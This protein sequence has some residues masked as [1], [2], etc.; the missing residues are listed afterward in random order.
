MHTHTGLLAIKFAYRILDELLWSILI[1]GLTFPLSLENIN[2][3]TGPQ[4]EGKNSHADS[5]GW[6]AYLV[7]YIVIVE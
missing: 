5:S 2:V 1:L 4:R 3:I 6:L 7:L